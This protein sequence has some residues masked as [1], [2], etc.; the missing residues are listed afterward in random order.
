MQVT[1]TYS[2]LSR[3]SKIE[4][5]VKIFNGYQWFSTV[6]KD[7]ATDLDVRLGWFYQRF[8]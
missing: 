6:A 3:I 5:V 8:E 4:L 7:F 2:Q 1:K